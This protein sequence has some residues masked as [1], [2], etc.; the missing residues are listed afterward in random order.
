MRK[1]V[2]LRGA[3]GV[4][5]TSFLKKAGLHGHV[6]SADAIRVILSSAVLGDHGR[7]MINQEPSERIFG[8]FRS[9]LQERMG[10][11]ET[12]AID[13]TFMY[14]K[15]IRQCAELAKKNRYQVACVDFS[16]FPV[17]EAIQQDLNRDEF[18]RV[19]ANKIRE[20]HRMI[21]DHPEDVFE[22]IH[23]IPWKS[24]ES[25]IAGLNAW[26]AEPLHDFSDRAGILHIGDL[27]G[28][29]TVLAGPGGPLEKGF[30]D[31]FEYV[32][33]GDLLDRGVENGR[34]LKWFVE[35]AV[36]RSNV[37]FTWG[38]HE[39]HLHHFAS[40]AENLSDEFASRT[41]PQLLE[42]GITEIDAEAVCAKAVDFLQY[43]FRE[44]IVLVTHGGLSAM[45]ARPELVSSRQCTHGTGYWEAPVDATFDR[46]TAGNVYQVH[47]HRNYQRVP[48]QAS[49]R[50]FNL[51]DAVEFGGNL[52]TALLNEHG[53][54]T[55]AYR[56]RVFRPRR[57]WIAIDLNSPKRIEKI[58]RYPYWMRAEEVPLSIDA[59]TMS[60]M[61]NHSGVVERT[62]TSFP[63]VASFNF[64]KKVF[65]DRSWDDVVMKARGLF[66][67]VDSH[68]IVSRG[69]EKFFNIGERDETSMASLKKS[70]VFPITVYVKENGFLGNVGYDKK[71]DSVFVASKSTPDGSFAEMFR[72]ILKDTIDPAKMDE[73][74][75]YLRDAEASMT[76]EV[77]DPVNDPHMIEYRAPKIVLLDIIRRTV[78]FEKADEKTLTEAAAMFGFERKTRLIQF[79]RWEEFQGFHRKV[80]QNFNYTVNGAPVEGVVI[81]DAAGFM[82]KLKTPYYMFWKR[83]RGAKDRIITTRAKNT[84]FAFSYATRPDGSAASENEVELAR[85][86]IEWCQSKSSEELASDIISLRNRF[87][88]EVPQTNP[89]MR[90]VSDERCRSALQP[91]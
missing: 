34:L 52:R 85:E 90:R 38:N 70:L 47:G 42:A 91:R 68:E 84:P 37:H 2:I 56:N 7:M 19:G 14:A 9:I 46:N 4:G 66:F 76:F 12:L 65:Y 3:Q 74:R 15:D 63:H 55:A 72:T 17:N 78:K 88:S 80:S 49:E 53:W 40:G 21:L 87:Q 62:N 23:V 35:K 11:G 1:L 18:E 61:R 45:P 48:I 32:F 69:Y 86:F 64:S 59:D 28:C 22:G 79:K 57:E 24:D 16:Q 36:P 58:S 27:Q 73:L 13:M 30:R 25:H 60:S 29:F 31:D 39:D 81:E 10:R 44:K 6:L 50:S 51:E 8:M 33:V 71:T 5:K 77:I 43:R 26:L 83:L 67:D 41:L 82:T 89:L 20:V 54:T 75:R